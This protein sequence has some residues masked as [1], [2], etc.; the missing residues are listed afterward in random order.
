MSP[1]KNILA[2]SRLDLKH[3]LIFSFLMCHLYSACRTHT[4]TYFCGRATDTIFFNDISLAID[5]CKKQ[6]NSNIWKFYVIHLCRYYPDTPNRF[7]EI[8]SFSC[9]SLVCIDV[10]PDR[11]LPSPLDFDVLLYKQKMFFVTKKLKN[12]VYACTRKQKSIKSYSSVLDYLDTYF[13]QFTY[14][15]SNLKLVFA[16]KS[17]CE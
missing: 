10:L 13:I 7:E 15:H 3:I 1:L 6:N 16:G 5:S 2:I 4:D 17:Y 11:T 12:H 8:N 14:H 9:D